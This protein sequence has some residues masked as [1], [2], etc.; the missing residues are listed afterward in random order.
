AKILDVLRAGCDA[1]EGADW[2][3]SADSTVVRAHQHAAGARR[4]RAAEL[5]RGAAP[6]DKNPRAGR[7]GRE[8]LGRSRGGLTTKIHLVGD[9]LSRASAH[10]SLPVNAG[11]TPGLTPAKGHDPY[12]PRGHRPAPPPAG[13][14]EGRKGVPPRPHPRLLAPPP[15]PGGHPG[16]GRPEKPPPCP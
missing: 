8:A 2:T 4:A 9:R 13:P 1:A 7:P 11:S 12:P 15:H 6:N 5:A 10:A 14:G 16:Q 3:V